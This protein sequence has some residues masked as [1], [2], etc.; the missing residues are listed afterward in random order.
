MYSL[1]GNTYFWHP[2]KCPIF[3]YKKVYKQAEFFKLINTQ[4]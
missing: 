4:A 2:Y 3:L 1:I